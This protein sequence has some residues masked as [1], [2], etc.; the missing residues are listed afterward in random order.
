[1]R[2]HF[3]RAPFFGRCPRHG[4]EAARL[5]A[6]EFREPGRKPV[7]SFHARLSTKYGTDIDLEAV[8]RVA[9]RV[10]AEDAELQDEIELRT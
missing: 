6:Y 4:V 9:R 8:I 10:N 1:M 7:S 2:G 5:E 3:G